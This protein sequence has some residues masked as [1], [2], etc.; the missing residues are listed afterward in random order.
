MGECR[1][2]EGQ[3]VPGR[4]AAGGTNRLAGIHVREGLV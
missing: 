3:G 2:V 4:L 1:S